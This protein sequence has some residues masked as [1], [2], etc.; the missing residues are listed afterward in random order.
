M[1]GGTVEG[2]IWWEVAGPGSLLDKFG[3]V[4]SLE[5]WLH[6]FC[7]LSPPGL[8]PAAPA[9]LTTQQ[10]RGGRMGSQQGRPQGQSW[11]GHLPADVEGWGVSVLCGSN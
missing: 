11:A 1:R 9:P 10:V 3:S 5:K 8:S 6:P 7:T 2:R 4:S